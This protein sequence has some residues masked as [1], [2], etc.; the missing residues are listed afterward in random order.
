MLSSSNAVGIA[1]YGPLTQ[2][3]LDFVEPRIRAVVKLRTLPSPSRLLATCRARRTAV[4][5]AREALDQVATL[6]AS[7]HRLLRL[8]VLRELARNGATLRPKEE[9]MHGAGHQVCANFSESLHRLLSCLLELLRERNGVG[10]D[11][12]VDTDAESLILCIFRLPLGPPDA[13]GSLSL[14]S[15]LDEVVRQRADAL[16]HAALHAVLLVAA[17]ACRRPSEPALHVVLEHL[18]LPKS[19]EHVCRMLQIL[20]LL[21]PHSPRDHPEFCSRLTPILISLAQ[22]RA[23]GNDVQ[24]TALRLLGRVMPATSSS[25]VPAISRQLCSTLGEALWG[26]ANVQPRR[27]PL[28]LASDASTPTTGTQ[29]DSWLWGMPPIMTRDLITVCCSLSPARGEQ[30][31]VRSTFWSPLTSR[32][33]ASASSRPNSGDAAEDALLIWLR[34]GDDPIAL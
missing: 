25:C 31:R 3:I 20:T 26:C 5:D 6:L 28:V 30:R 1:K 34:T 4:L 17:S 12:S 14:A 27:T 7:P 15:Y 18:S 16:S 29:R 9:M 33:V 8:L 24:Q 22:S 11:D 23:K 19:S 2:A 10:V 21:L 32:R 13:A